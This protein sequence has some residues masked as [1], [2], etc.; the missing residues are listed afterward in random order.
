M[1]ASST[2]ILM[3]TAANNSHLRPGSPALAAGT[4]DDLPTGDLDLHASPGLIPEKSISAATK[5]Q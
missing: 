1:R 4:V 5:K 3:D 2:R